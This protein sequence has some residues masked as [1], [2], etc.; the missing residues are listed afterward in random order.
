MRKPEYKLT[1]EKIEELKTLVHDDIENNRVKKPEFW[2][3]SFIISRQIREWAYETE[4]AIK[5]M[6][7]ILEYVPEPQNAS[8]QESKEAIEEV[9][10]EIMEF[11]K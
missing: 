4:E 2:P 1:E 8:E 5:Y 11:S 7:A 10:D 3:A 6:L 9:I